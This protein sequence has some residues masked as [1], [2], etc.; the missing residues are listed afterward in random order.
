MQH[1]YFLPLRHLPLIMQ[2]TRRDVLARYRGSLLG[3]GWSFLTPLLTLAVYTFVFRVIFK[4]RWG[5]ENTAISSS[6]CR[7]TAAWSYSCCSRKS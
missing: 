6:R 7:C 3:L 5:G 1:P 4:A 2:F